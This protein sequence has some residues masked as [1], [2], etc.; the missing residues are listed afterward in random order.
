[1]CVLLKYKLKYSAVNQTFLCLC[2]CDSESTQ[3]SSSLVRVSWKTTLQFWLLAILLSLVG[4]RVSS[5]IVL[6]FCLRAVS[7]WGSA[8]LV[9]SETH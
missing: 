9:S 8:G 7:A 5:L 3:R 4:S 2:K 1:M 6:E